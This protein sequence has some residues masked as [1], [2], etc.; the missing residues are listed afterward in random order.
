[1]SA[2]GGQDS[3][4]DDAR[5]HRFVLETDAGLAEL[6]YRVNGNRL[7]VVHTEVPETLRGQGIAGRL[8]R[9]AV[10]RAAAGGLVVVPLCPYARTWLKDHPEAAATVTVDWGT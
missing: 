1:V 7:V 10:E 4:V 3:I 5:D 6:V 2:G 9:A 8:V